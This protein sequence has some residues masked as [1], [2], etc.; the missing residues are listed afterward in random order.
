MTIEKVRELLNELRQDPKT[1]SLTLEEIDWYDENFEDGFE[2]DA[3]E[4]MD[5][6]TLADDIIEAR[7]VGFV[8]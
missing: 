3:Y 8:R 1:Y 4:D 2:P 5:A 6:N 7:T